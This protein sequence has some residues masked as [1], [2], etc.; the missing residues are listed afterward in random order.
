MS[1]QIA[2]AI[3]DVLQSIALIVLAGAVALHVRS[4]GSHRRGGRR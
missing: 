1:A 2:G 3:T 4:H